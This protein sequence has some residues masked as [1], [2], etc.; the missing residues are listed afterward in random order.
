MDISNWLWLLLIVLGLLWFFNTFKTGKVSGSL[1]QTQWKVEQINNEKITNNNPTMEFTQEK[2]VLRFSG[3]AGCN[4]YFGTVAFPVE[5]ESM[6]KNSYLP[7][8]FSQVGN[9]L[10]ACPQEQM[11]TEQKFLQA[12]ERIYY[13]QMN[14]QQLIL[15]DENQ[16][17]ILTLSKL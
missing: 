10:M 16:N 7:I 13:Y 12:L 2:S 14:N 4:R 5:S 9:T 1:D 8:K 15:L 6:Q 3:F 17:P 11:D